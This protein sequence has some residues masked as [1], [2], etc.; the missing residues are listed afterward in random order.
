MYLL[1]ISTNI[2]FKTLL[3]YIQPFNLQCFE[4]SQ[5]THFRVAETLTLTIVCTWEKHVEPIHVFRRS[6]MTAKLLFW[7]HEGSLESG[8][9]CCEQENFKTMSQDLC[10]FTQY[11]DGITV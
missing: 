11:S 2:Q 9:N 5:D 3:I 6:H 4:F 7:V 10:I 1:Y 8:A